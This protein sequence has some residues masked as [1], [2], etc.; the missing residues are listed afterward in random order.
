[1]KNVLRMIAVLS[2]LALLFAGTSCRKSSTSSESSDFA[3]SSL[4]LSDDNSSGEADSG[5]S[6]GSSDSQTSSGSSQSG[7]T[8]NT[9]SKVETGVISGS[10]N[11]NKQTIPESN[12]DYD[13]TLLKNPDRGFRMETKL[14][15]DGKTPTPQNDPTMQLYEQLAFYK[16]ESPQVAQAYFYLT[17]YRETETLPQ[18]AFDRMQKF[19]DA[20]RENN[21]KLLLRFAYQYDQSKSGGTVNPGDMGEA[22]QSIM[23]AH[24][25]QLKPFIEKNKDV[26]YAMQAGMIGAWGEWHSY[27]DEGAYAIDEAAL[28]KKLIEITPSNLVLQ[29]RYPGIKNDYGSGLSAAQKSRISYHNDSVFG[30]Y[31]NWTQGVNPGTASYKQITAEA[32]YFPIDG[33]M[34]WGWQINSGNTRAEAFA[35]AAKTEIKWQNI[36]GQLAEQRFTT[37]SL[38]HSY[39]ETE[40]GSGNG[41]FSYSMDKWKQRAVTPSVLDSM[42]LFYSDAW[43]KNSNGAAIERNAFEYLRDYLGYR[44]SLQN[45]SASGQLNR[46][47]TVSVSVDLINNGFSAAFNI[48]SGFAVLDQ[49]GNVVSTVKAG[50]PAEW[51]SRT[52]G[53][54]AEHNSS[55]FQRLGN[56]NKIVHSVSADIKLPSASGIYRIAFYAKSTNGQFVNFANKMTVTNGYHILQSIKVD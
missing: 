38:H 15:V 46:N 3:G 34:F 50:N 53:V 25:D 55:G 2:C 18:E 9:V 17:G 7:G 30:Y 21:I 35:D 42:G 20:A 28:L 54:N 12:S 23:M 39:R 26:I 48:E 32:P 13:G 24:L 33:E 14:Y 37:F 29:V 36:V 1:M 4:T 40:G 22:R 5:E 56:S 44:V 10:M 27:S 16:S 6:G 8:G 47:R 41:P 52:P 19:F 49:N 11:I 51:H 31:H 45:F 43:F